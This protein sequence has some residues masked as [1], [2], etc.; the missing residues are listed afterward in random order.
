MNE[1]TNGL[2]RD[3][4]PKKTDFRKIDH[5]ELQEIANNFNNRPRKVL[6]FLT[7]KEALIEELSIA[8]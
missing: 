5:Q 8:A 3:F 2:I 6:D 7:P 1:H 4:L